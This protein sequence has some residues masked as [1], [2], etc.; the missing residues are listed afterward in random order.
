MSVDKEKKVN[1]KLHASILIVVIA[2]ASFV[3]LNMD[4]D[5]SF[6]PNV[7]TEVNDPLALFRSDD[8]HKESETAIKTVFDEYMNYNFHQFGKTTW[9]DSVSATGAIINEYGVTFVIQSKGSQYDKQ[10]EN[11]LSA[12]NYFFSDKT[13][14][15]KY[16]IDRLIL[17][18]QD[19]KI[20]KEL[21]VIKW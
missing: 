8:Q 13:L 4:N 11:F 17:A 12:A 18:S 16:K 15:S 10:A 2:I 3:G 9:F 19:F 1:K 7:K 5:L 6:D 20:I 14:E 21:D